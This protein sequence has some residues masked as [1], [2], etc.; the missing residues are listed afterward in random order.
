MIKNAVHQN[1]ALFQLVELELE[2]PAAFAI[3]KMIMF[4]RV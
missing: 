2:Y 4:I 1:E 3:L